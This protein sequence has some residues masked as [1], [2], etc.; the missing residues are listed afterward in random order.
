MIPSAAN[1]EGR[2]GMR[3]VF[4]GPPGSGKGTQA[5]RLRDEFGI[6][7][8]AAGDMLRAAVAKCSDLGSRVKQIMEEGKLVPD[9]LMINL[10]MDAIKAPE[11]ANGFILD[12]FPRTLIQAEKV[13]LITQVRHSHFSF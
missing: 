12:G 13:R 8:L 1:P 7:H 2:K 5:P 6:A 9:D 11:C 4:L 10:I 3:L